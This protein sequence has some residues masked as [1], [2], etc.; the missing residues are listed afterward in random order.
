MKVL[1]GTYGDP[2]SM[3]RLNNIQNGLF[4]IYKRHNPVMTWQESESWV[5][6]AA[7]N[8]KPMTL[9]VATWLFSIVSRAEHNALSETYCDGGING[10]VLISTYVPKYDKFLRYQCRMILPED[11]VF[12]QDTLALEATDYVVTFKDLVEY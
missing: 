11:S 1:I 12:N 8:Y 7:N 2:T 5:L 4:S 10:S 3:A 6:S 9:P